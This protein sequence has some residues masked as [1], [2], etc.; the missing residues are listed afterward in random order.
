MKKYLEQD[1]DNPKYL[2]HGS[3]MK[4]DIIRQN[5][6]ND[7]NNESVNIDYA[8]FLTPSFL[9]STA[10]AFKDTIKLNSKDLDW[11]FNIN[12]INDYPI[13]KMKNV[14]VDNNILGYVYVFKYDH[15]MIKD[16]STYQ[17]RCYQELIPIDIIEVCYKD[18]SC[19]YEII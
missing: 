4:L 7:S 1:I 3:P 9:V 5:L 10:Y 12:N 16:E 2:F 8:I 6:S 14:R 13:M 19:Y 18:Y 15:I 11:S 17:Y